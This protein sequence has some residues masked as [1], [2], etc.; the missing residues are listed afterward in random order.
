MSTVPLD[1]DAKLRFAMTSVSEMAAY[2]FPFIGGVHEV[3]DNN[4]GRLRGTALRLR[5]GEKNLLLSAC[6]VFGEGSDRMAATTFRGESPVELLGPP[7][8][9]S[10]TQDVAAYQLPGGN[11]AQGLAFWP[12][13][14]VDVSDNRL[15]TDF[16]FLH[17]FP[18]VRSHSTHLLG[19]AVVSDTL[20]YGAMQHEGTPEGIE[21]FQFAMD[22]DPANFRHADGSPAEWIDPHGLSGSPIWRIGAAGRSASTWEPSM[23]R[24]VGIVTTW[25]PDQK[26]LVATKL[27]AFLDALLEMAAQP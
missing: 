20:P 25:K 22:F 2:T 14:D 23:S 9:A 13:N 24:L 7:V 19:D 5:V 12:E 8:F 11:S 1:E 27:S 3:V 10:G 21:D 18:A 15:S 26:L 16:L 4:T 17:G 6:H